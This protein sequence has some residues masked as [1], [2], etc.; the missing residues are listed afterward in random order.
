[1]TQEEIREKYPD[2]DTFGTNKLDKRQV[3]IQTFLRHLDRDLE[4]QFLGLRWLINNSP[5]PDSPCFVTH[6]I[7]EL[8]NKLAEHL[9]VNLESGNDHV[10]NSKSNLIENIKKCV[11]TKPPSKKIKDIVRKSFREYVHKLKNVKD[12]KDHGW[13]NL[14]LQLNRTNVEFTEGQ[15]KLFIKSIKELRGMAI[16]ISHHKSSSDEHVSE[17]S[18]QLEEF[19]YVFISASTSLDRDGID[20]LVLE[21]ESDD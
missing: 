4:M 2:L 13:N 9:G 17:L 16:S 10:D 21:G 11:K 15:K 18:D 8:I 1:M 5:F 6:S 20:L 19:L 3:Q 12:V 14:V 7:R